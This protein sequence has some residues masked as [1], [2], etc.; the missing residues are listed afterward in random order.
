MKRLLPWLN[1]AP[2]KRF[3]HSTTPKR[4]TKHAAIA[5]PAAAALAAAP[6]AAPAAKATARAAIGAATAVLPWPQP[7]GQVRGDGGVREVERRCSSVAGTL[8]VQGWH[9]TPQI[10]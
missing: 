8:A 1:L 4:T 5:A 7:E 3:L 9:D 10:R 2:L 6:A